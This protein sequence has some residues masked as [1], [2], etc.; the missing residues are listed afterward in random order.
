VIENQGAIL[1]PPALASSIAETARAVASEMLRP[2]VI[3][4]F[5]LGFAGLGMVVI[6]MLL[7]AKKVSQAS[8]FEY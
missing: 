2:I 4:G 3:E 7:A 8:S 5:I 1:I 6:A